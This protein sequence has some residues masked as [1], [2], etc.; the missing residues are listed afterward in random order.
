[1]TGEG[2]Y[3]FGTIVQMHKPTRLEVANPA[4]GEAYMWRVPRLDAA[5]LWDGEQIEL[6]FDKVGVHQVHVDVVT[7]AQLKQYRATVSAHAGKSGLDVGKL[8]GLGDGAAPPRNASDNGDSAS[9]L[10]DDAAEQQG[11]DASDGGWSS[12]NAAADD[13]DADDDAD[14]WPLKA[15]G[16]DDGAARRRRVGGIDTVGGDEGGGDDAGGID[17]VGGDEGGDAGGDAGDGG[18]D[19]VGGDESTG[20][21]SATDSSSGGGSIKSGVESTGGGGVRS[22]AS[23]S[24]IKAG[25]EASSSSSDDDGVVTG[26]SGVGGVLRTG[27]VYEVTSKYVRRELRKLTKDDRELFFDALH[28]IYRVGQEVGV[29]LYGSNTARS[30]CSSPSTC[31]ARRA[32]ATTG[33]TTRAS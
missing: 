19:V 17:V 32:S 33:T 24:S 4:D 20:G 31:A 7:P 28:T 30:R 6:V 23:S 12:A 27:V 14:D 21:V 9:M 26:G 2:Y 22:T 3:P 18:G 16:G 5:Q 15:I 25:V 29:Q 13:N 8:L 1:M 11:V 10:H